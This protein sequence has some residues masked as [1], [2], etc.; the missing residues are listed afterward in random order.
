M[1]QEETQPE[2]RSGLVAL[3]QLEKAGGEEVGGESPEGE[4]RAGRLGVGHKVGIRLEGSQVRGEVGP[5]RRWPEVA[6]P[7]RPGKGG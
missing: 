2:D 4:Q 1:R 6:V 5:V 3:Y 7:R